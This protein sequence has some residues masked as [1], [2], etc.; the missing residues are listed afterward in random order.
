M[1]RVCYI[2]FSPTGGTKLVAGNIAKAMALELNLPMESFDITVP[3][4]REKI[5]NFSADGSHRPAR[6]RPYSPGP[7]AWQPAKTNEIS[8]HLIR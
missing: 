6:L 7:A 5:Y 4:G 8:A 3:E 2:Y 1:T